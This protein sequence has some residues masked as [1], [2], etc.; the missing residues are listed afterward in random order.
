MIMIR[1][2]SLINV[3][4]AYPHTEQLVFKVAHGKIYSLRVKVEV[5]AGHKGGCLNLNHQTTSKKK[6]EG[7][8][9]W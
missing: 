1:R 8:E 9:E 2:V 6:Y 7:E 4:N 5:P 3:T